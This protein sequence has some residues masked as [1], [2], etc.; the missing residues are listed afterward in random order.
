MEIVVKQL[1]ETTI[2][3]SNIADLLHSAFEERL[4]QGLR[5][6]CSFM[7]A[8][9]VEAK[10]NGGY[11]FV[12]FN[13]DTEELIGTVTIHVNTDKQGNVFGYHEYLAVSPK[14]KNKGVGTKL[15][16]AWNLLLQEKRAKYVYSD[17]AC[18]AR[19]SVNWHLK[20][21][22]Q[23]Y[24]L[25]S[26]RSTNYWSYVFIKYLDDS[27]RKSPLQLKLHY[28]RSWLF[29]RITRNKN[30]SDTVLGKLY[31]KIKCKN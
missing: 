1:S 14:A 20:N 8:E 15:A 27:I 24:E 29:I 11:V 2:T 17:T 9:Q 18:R 28:W 19:S 25:E 7:T 31:K 3:Y 22:F 23:I 4:Q 13:R 26:Y 30:G 6:T 16:E 5:F 21:G 10:M 12:A